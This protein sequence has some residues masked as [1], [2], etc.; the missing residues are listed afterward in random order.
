MSVCGRACAQVRMGG[1]CGRFNKAVEIDRCENAMGVRDSTKGA[2]FAGLQ[3]M[4]AT[5]AD[6]GVALGEADTVH[7][8]SLWKRRNAWPK[9]RERSLVP[10][11]FLAAGSGGIRHT[12]RT[13]QPSVCRPDQ[14]FC[15]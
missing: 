12:D 6:L 4:A 9:P 14:S 2:R 11:T 1:G 5:C 13:A 3:L 7:L 10:M 15:V 8:S